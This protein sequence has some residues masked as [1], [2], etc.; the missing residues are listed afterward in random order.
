MNDFNAYREMINSA[1][2]VSGRT[3]VDKKASYVLRGTMIVYCCLKCIL[4]ESKV[5]YFRA[6]HVIVFE[7][8][9]HSEI[10]L[11]ICCLYFVLW[12]ELQAVLSS[13]KWQI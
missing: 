9:V 6:Y 1:I 12:L 7:Q 5:L 2:L 4:S 8:P 3:A 13:S 11:F 10:E